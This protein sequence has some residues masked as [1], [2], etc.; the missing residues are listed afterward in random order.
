MAFLTR[1]VLS[2]EDVDMMSIVGHD[3]DFVDHG[4]FDFSVVESVMSLETTEHSDAIREL[5]EISEV[6]RIDVRQKIEEALEEHDLI[7][8]MVYNQ[9]RDPIEKASLFEYGV[10]NE[11][12]VNEYY[13][14]D[15]A[16]ASVRGRS[17]EIVICILETMREIRG[18]QDTHRIKLMCIDCLRKMAGSRRYRMEMAS[19][20]ALQEIMT[21]MKTMTESMDIVTGTKMLAAICDD[22][23]D[24]KRTFLKNDGLV[25]LIT[26]CRRHKKQ[27]YILHDVCLFIFQLCQGDNMC[28]V[29]T[30]VMDFLCYCIVE[31]NNKPR[32]M[33][34]V[35]RT[36]HTLTNNIQNRQQLK[37]IQGNVVLAE[38]LAQT[39]DATIPRSFIIPVLERLQYTLDVYE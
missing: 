22:N 9:I 12:I 10:Q 29:N 6:A 2:D 17:T 35:F 7:Q 11:S 39:E 23:E 20:G 13:I 8:D 28:V 21:A 19:R 26:I 3:D 4:E 16:H 33:Y 5:L 18:D 37:R 34:N 38:I 36:L 24:A 14:E 1:L 31:Y 25:F 27:K 15:Q 30:G 32:F